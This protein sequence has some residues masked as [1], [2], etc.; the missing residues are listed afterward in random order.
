MKPPWYMKISF[1]E[2][3]G[4][5]RVPPNLEVGLPCFVWIKFHW[6]Y[7][8]YVYLKWRIFSCQKNCTKNIDQKN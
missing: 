4:W 3:K 7:Y 1:K 2:R 5:I 8:C 6:I